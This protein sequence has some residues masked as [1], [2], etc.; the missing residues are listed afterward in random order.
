MEETHLFKNHS[1]GVQGYLY[2]DESG[3]RCGG[4]LHPGESIWL[5]ERDLKATAE[6]P[7]NAENNPLANG[8]LR[9]VP[10][11]ENPAH[12]RSIGL[13]ADPDP[14]PSDEEKAA[15]EAAE[16][17]EKD[18]LDK[19]EREKAEKAEKA[20]AKATAKE[21]KAKE[22]EAQKQAE[23]DA[24]K[25]PPPPGKVTPEESKGKASEEKA[26]GSKNADK[27][28]SEETAADKEE[29]GKRGE[30]KRSSDEAVATPDAEK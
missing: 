5:T 29:Q 8:N 20:K 30:G 14:E 3:K 25:Q 6:A 11:E 24:A 26:S 12:N 7:R 10:D 15:H 13:L 17:A 28:D 23:K 1:N 27:K 2:Y 21:Q 18:A 9:Q 19:A 16:A 22:A 4:A